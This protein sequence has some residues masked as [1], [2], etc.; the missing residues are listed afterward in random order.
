MMVFQMKD[1][2]SHYKNDKINR[3]NDKI[4]NEEL[5]EW[6]KEAKQD[7]QKFKIN[8][9]LKKDVNKPKGLCHICTKNKAKFSCLKCGKAVCSSCYFNILGICK[10]CVPKDL[11]DK[12]EEKTPNW[13]KVL[14]V[15]WV[16]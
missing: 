3:K 11:V 10:L 16:D 4:M 1:E 8:K 2:N 15:E 9:K 13:E 12:W 7:I 5:L 14:N 6:L